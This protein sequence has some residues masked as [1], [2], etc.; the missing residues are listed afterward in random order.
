VC[1]VPLVVL[2]HP[3]LLEFQVRTVVVLACFLFGRA[4]DGPPLDRLCAILPGIIGATAVLQVIPL[5]V[6]LA[7]ALSPTAS[8]RPG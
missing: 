4:N 7:K 3:A 1:I 6:G 8:M 5:P 2:I